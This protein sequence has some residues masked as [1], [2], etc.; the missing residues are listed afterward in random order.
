[1]KFIKGQTFWRYPTCNILVLLTFRLSGKKRRRRCWKLQCRSWIKTAEILGAFEA[2]LNLAVPIFFNK[3]IWGAPR[4]VGG[5]GDGMSSGWWLWPTCFKACLSRLGM[6]GMILNIYIY[7]CLRSWSLSWTKRALC[8][9]GTV[10]RFDGRCEAL[11]EPLLVESQGPL[12]LALPV[13]LK[14][15]YL[16]GLIWGIYWFATTTQN[17][18]PS[19]RRINLV[20]RAVDFKDFVQK[21][22]AMG[23]W[24]Q[25]ILWRWNKVDVFGVEKQ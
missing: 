1:M 19:Q 21:W 3:E 12:A 13:H 9:H 16:L 7:T 17:I 24:S 20:A 6:L 23:S 10:L 14:D 5:N 15:W 11:K 8:R 22:E 2:L 4:K 18:G 25:Y